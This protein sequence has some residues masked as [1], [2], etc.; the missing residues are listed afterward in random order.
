[1]FFAI[2]PSLCK[3]SRQIWHRPGTADAQLTVLCQYPIQVT[4]DSFCS[5][6]VLCRSFKRKVVTLYHDIGPLGSAALVIHI[7]KGS[8][9]E[10]RAGDGGQ[11][12]RYEDAFQVMATVESKC[13]DRRNPFR[14][15]NAID[16]CSVLVPGLRGIVVEAI[17]RPTSADRKHTLLANRPPETAPCTVSSERM[18]GCG[19]QRLIAAITD[20]DRL[21]AAE[22]A[23]IIDIRQTGTPVE[24]V[25]ADICQAGWKCYG[26]Q[27]RAAHEIIK[28]NSSYAVTKNDSLYFIAI[29]QPCKT[30]GGR[31]VIPDRPTAFNP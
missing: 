7:L 25:H 21:P 13:T 10:I 17:H 11:A 14:D 2:A 12:G 19:R 5:D 9:V 18:E 8:R 30:V 23:L 15:F 28:A 27:L 3:V 1:M 29:I 4:P 6:K 22:H 16:R 26:C 24:C 20:A 31:I